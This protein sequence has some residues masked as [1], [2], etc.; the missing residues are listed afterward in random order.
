MLKGVLLVNAAS[1][2]AFGLLF[3]FD[4]SVI[5]TF[6]GDPPVWLLQLLGVG[7]LANAA[8]LIFTATRAEPSRRDVLSFAL[9]DAAWVVSTV[10]LIGAGL[11]V[12]TTA[13]V[14]WAIGVGLFVGF[15]G[16]AQWKL[17]PPARSG[18]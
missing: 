15:C 3:L 10:G 11:W 5:A 4:G 12:T 14:L 1:C 18:S 7:L 6:L 2:A 16:L 9:G 13:G 8:W 17:A